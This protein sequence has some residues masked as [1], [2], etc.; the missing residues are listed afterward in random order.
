MD[1]AGA[2]MSRMKHDAS[3]GSTSSAMALLRRA[4]MSH[5]A[6]EARG[7]LA[8]AGLVATAEEASRRA[9]TPVRVLRRGPPDTSRT[10]RHL[11]VLGVGAPPDR[12]DP[13]V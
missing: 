6:H 13:G 11:E 7:L 4:K 12:R 2:T 1:Q 5:L 9:T 10:Q 8:R 3:R